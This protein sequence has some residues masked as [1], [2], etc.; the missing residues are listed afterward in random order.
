M[1][2]RKHTLWQG[3]WEQF[4][5]GWGLQQQRQRQQF[6]AFESVPRA[7]ILA[8]ECD[9]RTRIYQGRQKEHKDIAQRANL[10]KTEKVGRATLVSAERVSRSLLQTK[11]KKGS[12]AAQPAS[13][14]SAGFFTVESPP[15]T[16]TE[17]EKPTEN[18]APRSC[19]I[20]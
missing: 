16:E 10:G 2:R 12:Q 4:V 17:A 9:E 14:P 6:D 11:F 5:N 19:S 8:K 15:K 1:S 13:P 18:T 20:T 3:N 7:E